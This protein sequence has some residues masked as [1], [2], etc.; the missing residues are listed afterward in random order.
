MADK[1]TALI[2]T[3][4]QAGAQLERNEKGKDRRTTGEDRHR[5]NKNHPLRGTIIITKR[6]PRQ[7]TNTNITFA[8]D[9]A[10]CASRT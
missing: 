4:H 5:A 2:S 3:T 1:I 8:L 10:A 7:A 6:S 9:T